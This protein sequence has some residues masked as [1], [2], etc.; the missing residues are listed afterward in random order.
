[1]VTHINIVLESQAHPTSLFTDFGLL[2]KIV[3]ALD[4]QP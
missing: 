2:Y 1:M 3:Y 4:V